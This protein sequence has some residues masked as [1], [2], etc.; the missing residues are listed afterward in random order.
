MNIRILDIGKIEKLAGLGTCKLYRQ[1]SINGQQEWS[2][3]SA[4]M[5]QMQGKCGGVTEGDFGIFEI[6]RYILTRGYKRF[7][8]ADFSE[9]SQVLVYSRVMKN[10]T[11]LLTD[12]IVTS[13]CPQSHITRGL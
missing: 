6:A 3:N 2:N 10:S 9:T 5:G 7:S 8:M 12:L 11:H 1:N 4:R 13:D